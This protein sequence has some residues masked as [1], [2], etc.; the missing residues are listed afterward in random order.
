MLKPKQKEFIEALTEIGNVKASCEK[1]GMSRSTYYEW[2]K[3]R[4]FSN[5][6][7]LAQNIAY[8][9][10]VIDAKNLYLNAVEML[11]NLLT[12]KDESIKL[13]TILA[14]VEKLEKSVRSKE[15]DIRLNDIYKPSRYH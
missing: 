2:L 9:Y 11:K 15:A 4:E 1:L 7:M 13:K 6:L 12:S 14:I 5:E 3:D 8:K 10:S